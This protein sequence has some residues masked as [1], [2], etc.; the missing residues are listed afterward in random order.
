MKTS[1]KRRLLV[2]GAVATLAISPFIIRNFRKSTQLPTGPVSTFP[3]SVDLSVVPSGKVNVV[4]EYITFEPLTIPAD[5]VQ[6]WTLNAAFSNDNKCLFVSYCSGNDFQAEVCYAPLDKS[7]LP[8]SFVVLEKFGS[9][10]VVV[11]MGCSSLSNRGSRQLSYRLREHVKSA[12]VCKDSISCVSFHQRGTRL[13]QLPDPVLLS[14]S[15]FTAERLALSGISKSNHCWLDERNTFVFPNMSGTLLLM[16]N[17][18]KNVSEERISTL[19]KFF[20]EAD[21]KATD[22]RVIISNM[23]IADNTIKFLEA[24]RTMVR[25]DK[26]DMFTDPYRTETGLLVSIGFDGGV[27]SE[28]AFPVPSRNRKTLITNAYCLFDSS[29]FFLTAALETPQEYFVFRFWGGDV[30]PPDTGINYVF[31]PLLILPSGRHLLCAREVGASYVDRAKKLGIRL[32]TLGIIELPFK[33]G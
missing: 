7:G 14:E 8:Q 33:I 3:V 17:C 18:E 31:A 27:K 32:S 26:F 28:E 30:V 23:H 10:S 6:P 1:T 9:P 5:E 24:P 21:G 15:E 16:A 13:E 11:G 2:G 4:N 29:E 12:N 22:H 19:R 20:N 25:Q